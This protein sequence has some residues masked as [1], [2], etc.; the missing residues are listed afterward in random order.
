MIV[1]KAPVEIFVCIYLFIFYCGMLDTLDFHMQLT[2]AACPKNLECDSSG[3][4]C[5]CKEGFSEES[6]CCKC[7]EDYYPDGT[8]CKSKLCT[9][10][11]PM[12]RRNILLV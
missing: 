12:H 4:N 7:K 9:S 10:H 6:E 1:K 5:R 8:T 2:F 3:A 11:F